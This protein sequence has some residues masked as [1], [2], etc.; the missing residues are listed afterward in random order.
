MDFQVLIEPGFADTGWC[1]RYME[2]IHEEISRMGAGMRIISEAEMGDLQP[3]KSAVIAVGSLCDWVSRMALR[4][5]ECRLRHVLVA[6][7]PLTDAAVCCVSMDYPSGV[8]HLVRYLRAAGRTH[9]ALVGVYVNSLTDMSKRDGFCSLCAAEDV[10]YS[11][12]DVAGCCRAFIERLEDYDCVICAND[13]VALRLLRALREAHVSVPERLY[14]TVIGESPLCALTAPGITTLSLNF[15]SVGRSAVRL[16]ALLHKNPSISSLNARLEGEL[17]PRA[18]TA[19]FADHIADPISEC[20]S[21]DTSEGISEGISEDILNG[22]SKGISGALSDLSGEKMSQGVG[23]AFGEDDGVQELQRLEKLISNLTGVDHLL[24][25]GLAR[26]VSGGELAE[27]L[28]LS[29]STLKYR[30]RRMLTLCAAYDRAEMLDLV[31]RY[32]A[33]EDLERMNGEMV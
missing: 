12:G 1:T 22:I 24:L 33:T 6:P 15:R 28:F 9:C 29:E 19:C 13:F 18:S 30:V 8:R 32:L 31:N 17:I 5:R 23:A 3:E 21:E 4:F 20:D 7:T 26:G 27:S 10:F 2:G 14:L 25:A 11:A 16:C